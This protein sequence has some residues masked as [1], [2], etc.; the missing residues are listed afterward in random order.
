[1]SSALREM[2]ETHPRADRTRVKDYDEA[3][4]A[5]SLCVEACTLCADACLG[6]TEHLARLQRCITTDLDCADVASATL[7]LLLRQT[8]APNEVIH[9]QLHACVV[10][11]QSCADECT[12]HAQMHA[13]CRHCAEI[14]HRCQQRCNFLLGEITSS[15]TAE[16]SDA[17]DAG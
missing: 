17:S 10:A 14:C 6:E 12:K 8:E 9:A 16:E 13:H 1:M 15:G 11:C 3:V 5:L 4:S 7:R 2:W